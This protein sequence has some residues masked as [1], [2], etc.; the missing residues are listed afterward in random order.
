MSPLRILFQVL[1]L[2]IRLYNVVL[3]LRVMLTWL[4]ISPYS[5]RFAKILYDLTE[6]VLEPIRAI[7]P[8]IA[9]LDLSP[10]VVMLLLLALERALGILATGL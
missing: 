9:M 5:N 8:P 3:L 7:I 1:I 6:P 10:L 4:R 2:L